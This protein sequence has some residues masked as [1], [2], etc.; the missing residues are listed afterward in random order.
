MTIP[1]PNRMPEKKFI[2]SWSSFI[3]FSW[4]KKCIKIADTINKIEIKIVFPFVIL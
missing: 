2:N 4:S 3:V 1:T